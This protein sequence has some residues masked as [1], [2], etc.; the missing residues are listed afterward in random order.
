LCKAAPWRLGSVLL[1][2]CWKGLGLSKSSGFRPGQ[3]PESP[4]AGGNRRRSSRPL[5]YS[6]EPHHGG[7]PR[8]P[9]GRSPNPS[10]PRSP[11]VTKE[12]AGCLST[13]HLAPFR[14]EGARLF[15]ACTLRPSSSVVRDRARRPLISKHS[16]TTNP[17][18]RSEFRSEETLRTCR[19]ACHAWQR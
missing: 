19:S 5:H 10:P 2:N 11:G 12:T 9:T 7:G 18:C 15:A 14:G 17:T 8:M 6:F 13:S 3:K 4:E 1:G 16:F